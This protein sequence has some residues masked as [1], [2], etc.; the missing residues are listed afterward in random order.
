MTFAGADPIF[1]S[2]LRLGAAFGIPVMAGAVAAAAIWRLRTGRGQ[3]LHLDL[4]RAIHGI[5][6]HYAWQPTLNGMP[7]AIASLFDNFFLLAPY[8]TRDGRTVMASGVYP[9]MAAN[10]LRFLGSPPE[11]DS[12][13]AAFA[14]WDSAELEEAANAR[15][16]A[17]TIART[18]QEWLSHRQGAL[19]PAHRWS[20]SKRSPTASRGRSGPARSRCRE[21]GRC[22][23]RTR[24]PGRRSSP[25]TKEHSLLT[26]D[27]CPSSLKRTFL[28]RRR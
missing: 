26:P 8:K 28:H 13:V 6:A 12:I 15:G 7:H 11:W 16:L 20:R 2:R 1:E 24:S 10:W 27:G 14:R 18:P 25:E 23:L 3:D 9:Q 5:V 19:L 22:R 17:R 21:S 4:R